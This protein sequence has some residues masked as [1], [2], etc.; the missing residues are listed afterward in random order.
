MEQS[1]EWFKEG[2]KEIRNQRIDRIPLRRKQEA[3]KDPNRFVTPREMLPGSM[4]MFYYDPKTKATLPYYDQFPLIFC[5]NVSP[6]GFTGI[7]LHYLRPTLRMRLF[8]ALRTRLSNRDYDER[9]RV[10][11]SYQTLRAAS[12]YR[13]FRPC[14][15]QY[16]SGHVISK[17][18]WVHPSQWDNTIMLPNE[19]FVGLRTTT[20]WK[21][22]EQMI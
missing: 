14:F 19:S 1:I 12:K 8:E 22:S 6:K 17:M 16:L 11:I 10:L 13:Y 9:T 7:N 4:Y 5:L 15:K 2:L 20:I 3:D 18:K 21:L